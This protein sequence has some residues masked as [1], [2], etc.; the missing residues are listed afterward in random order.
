[1]DV[2]RHPVRRSG[3]DSPSRSSSPGRRRSLALRRST[4]TVADPARTTSRTSRSVLT[5]SEG[6]PPR[7]LSPDRAEDERQHEQAE[8]PSDP[9]V[10]E[11]VGP[12]RGLDPSRTRVRS[13]ER[14]PVRLPP[15]P[16][17]GDYGAGAD[18]GLPAPR[19]S[20]MKS[21]APMV[22]HR[23]PESSPSESSISSARSAGC[24]G[25]R[26]LHRVDRASSYSR[27]L[28]RCTHDDRSCSAASHQRKYRLW[29][30]ICRSPRWIGDSPVRAG[31]RGQRHDSAYGFLG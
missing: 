10:S 30:W 23:S 3:G 6:P 1:M 7:P 18:R 14:D 15:R 2:E 11:R 28:S 29:V 4:V 16:A 31:G 17:R 22:F 5:C 26:L 8:R 25:F 9:A 20:C 27:S 19:R 21:R 12:V 24:F 13:G